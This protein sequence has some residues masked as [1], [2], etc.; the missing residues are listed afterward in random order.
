MGIIALITVLGSKPDGSPFVPEPGRWIPAFYAITL[1]TNAL[2][3]ALLAIR[4]WILERRMQDPKSTPRVIQS[5]RRIRAINII[6]DSA[7]L[8]SFTL[9][10]NLIV[11]LIKSNG[12][13]IMVDIL[14]PIISIA[15]YLV[16]LRAING[17]NAGLNLGRISLKA[18]VSDGS[19]DTATTAASQQG[20][21]AQARHSVQIQLSDIVGIE[22]AD[23]DKWH[24]V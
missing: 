2:S 18:D 7:A 20:A 10:A 12:N 4:I 13:F 8:Y 17:A 19:D 5:P 22:R 23:A 24:A 3:T 14:M 15:F 9:L 11:F 21:R 6:L 16:I 1:S